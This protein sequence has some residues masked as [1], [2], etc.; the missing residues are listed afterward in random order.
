MIFKTIASGFL[1]L[2]LCGAAH[3]EDLTGTH[4]EREAI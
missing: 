2:A 4:V 1:A 3:A